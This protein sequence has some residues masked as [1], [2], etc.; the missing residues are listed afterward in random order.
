MEYTIPCGLSIT[1]YLI[2]LIF[3]VVSLILF[4]ISIDYS[5]KLPFE[6]INDL[7]AN[8]N[9]NYMTD[10]ISS[11]SYTCPNG[12]EPF[13]TNDWPG[14]KEGCVC[15]MVVNIGN[16][17]E[18]GKDTDKLCK[19]IKGIEKVSYRTW[20]N[21]RVCVQRGDKTYFDLNI[22]KD[23]CPSNFPKKCGV[24]DSQNNILC[25]LLTENC[26]INEIQILDKFATLSTSKFY[27]SSLLADKKIVFTDQSTDMLIPIITKVSDE[28]PCINPKYENYYKGQSYVLDNYFTYETCS[29]PIGGSKREDSNYIKL[30][31]Y[32]SDNILRENGIYNVYN[33]IS[34]LPL[35]PKDRL[36][37]TSSL[38]TRS[39]YGI[40]TTC[41]S[42]LINNVGNITEFTQ[43]LDSLS[44]H[45]QSY[46]KY[47]YQV[48]IPVIIQLVIISIWFLVNLYKL[49]SYTDY[50]SP[51]A[52]F[53]VIMAI[54]SLV[55]SIIALGF[56]CNVIIDFNNLDIVQLSFLTGCLDETSEILLNS[57]IESS[58]QMK[59]YGIAST[60]LIGLNIGL[61][62][63]ELLIWRC[64]EID[65]E[66]IDKGKPIA[67]EE[68]KKSE[69]A[70]NINIV[71]FRPT[72]VKSVKKSVKDTDLKQED[73]N[74][75][76]AESSGE[77]EKENEVTKT[78]Q[79][80]EQVL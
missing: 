41:K 72:K 44:I 60:I 19:D 78:P 54:A 42:S 43:Y 65:P 69:A 4:F 32:S 17:K 12:Y 16:C 2:I 23:T 40:D 18:L 22:Y 68:N 56:V 3:S 79:R 73:K 6:F 67:S 28:T 75:I 8:W 66:S 55:I 45:S 51:V 21:K 80:Q 14:T 50:S 77:K 34:E 71:E 25:V 59:T 10:I 53:I 74:K 49:G 37:H 7:K 46:P 61:L 20:N 13:F 36:N 1:L 29:V 52:F 76:V 9:L 57:F 38:F 26:P 39:Y 62:F 48:R 27:H 31:T 11:D 33:K 35:F 30:D 64:C 70:E 5:N 58:E 15:N 63:T 24:I 47:L